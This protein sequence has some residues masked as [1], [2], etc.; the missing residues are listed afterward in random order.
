MYIFYKYWFNILEAFFTIRL[1]I[2]TTYN[3][4]IGELG[5]N[6]NPYFN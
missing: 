5:I 1:R 6:P 2:A 4:T 3:L